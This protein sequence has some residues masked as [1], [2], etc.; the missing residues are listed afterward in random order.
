MSLPK[1]FSLRAYT[2][3]C[4]WNFVLSYLWCL[5]LFYVMDFKRMCGFVKMTGKGIF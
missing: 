3:G 1:S 4:Y 5:R 2:C